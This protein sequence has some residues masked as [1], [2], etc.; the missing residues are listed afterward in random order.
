MGELNEKLLYRIK[1]IL[2]ECAKK[3]RLIE[4]GKLSKELNGA[5]SARK[6]NEPL[7]EISLRCIKKG[8]PPLSVLVVNK[9]TQ[10]PG[11]GFFTWVAA[12]MGYNNLP[13]SEW[14]SFFEEQLEKV[15]IFDQW[16]KF[17][18]Y[19][20]P[21]QGIVT[22][23]LEFNPEKF[24]YELTN[25]AYLKGKETPF[26]II[27]VKKFLDIFDQGPFVYEVLLLEHHEIISKATVEDNN[28]KQLLTPAKYKGM[29]LLVTKNPMVNLDDI[30]MVHY[31]EDRLKDD[32][33]E[34]EPSKSVKTIFDKLKTKRLSY[35]IKQDLQAEMSQNASFYKDGE[36]K[37]YYGNRYERKTINRVR[38]IEIHGTT[39]VVCGF[40]F[41]KV[42]GEHGKDFIEVHH[43][44]PLST[45]DEAVEID[46]ENDLVPVCSN[47]HRMLHRKRENV[48]SIEE[49]KGLL[50]KRVSIDRGN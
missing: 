5:I 8:Y 38:A 1:E 42:Y 4:Y 26:Y 16:D 22:S 49:L 46:P 7:G 27:T 33:W 21:N 35:I 43:I 36:V 9:D 25:K 50:R 17:L 29:E 15:F 20:K 2:I 10:R 14:E 32:S 45:F 6:L 41:E 39:C 47:C 34:K 3:N 44:K 12:K 40:N 18:T 31:K 24:D 28:S 13:G 48:L 19:Y 30:S 11:E 37:Q 23:S